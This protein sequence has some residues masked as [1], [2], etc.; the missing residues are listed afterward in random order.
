[1]PTVHVFGPSS[2]NPTK[3]LVINTT[4]QSKD[5]YQA[6]SPFL[7]EPLGGLARNVENLWQYSKLYKEYADTGGNPTTSY[8]AWRDT[9]FAKN[10]GERYPMG[11][12]AK[13]LCS[14]WNGEKL[15]YIEARR[16]IYEPQY[17]AAALM[18]CAGQIQKLKQLSEVYQDLWLFD[19]DGYDHLAYDMTLAEVGRNSEKPMG[20][21]FILASILTGEPIF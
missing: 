17:R 8:Y 6:F 13:P 10:Y 16:R 18:H 4:S 12:G 19:F 5:E 15:G 9:G 14:L 1:M 21:A 11:K 3:G 7:L 2:P 20:H